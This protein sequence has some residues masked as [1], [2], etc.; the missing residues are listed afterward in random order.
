M[1]AAAFT[2]Q[3]KPGQTSGLLMDNL[4]SALI[5]PR[6]RPVGVQSAC[7]RLSAEANSNE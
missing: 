1:A 5:R 2:V 4:S 6:Y 3:G 7:L